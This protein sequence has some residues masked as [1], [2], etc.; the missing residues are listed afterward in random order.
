MGNMDK[1]YDKDPS[2]QSGDHRFA[3]AVAIRNWIKHFFN[4]TDEE[5]K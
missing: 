1:F 3:Q 5:L 4:I 2:T